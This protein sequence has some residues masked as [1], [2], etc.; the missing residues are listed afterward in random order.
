M[1]NPS[2]DALAPLSAPGARDIR[3]GR[4]DPLRVGL[5][6]A[7]LSKLSGIPV[8]ALWAKFKVICDRDDAAASAGPPKIVNAPIARKGGRRR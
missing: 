3:Y 8:E 1:T 4:L 6:I 5:V 2:T 7:R